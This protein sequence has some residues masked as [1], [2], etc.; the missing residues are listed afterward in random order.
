MAKARLGSGARFKALANKFAHKGIE[1]PAGLA[2]KIGREKYG[3]KRF[4]ALAKKGKA[5][6]AKDAS[7][8][9]Y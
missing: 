8:Q 2:A 7:D 6:H 3:K 1:N 9:N 5:R 4:Q